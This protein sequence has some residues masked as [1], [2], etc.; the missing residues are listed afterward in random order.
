MGSIDCFIATFG[1]FFDLEKRVKFECLSMKFLTK[2]PIV[3]QQWVT[4]TS[5]HHAKRR[6]FYNLKSTVIFVW[7]VLIGESSDSRILTSTSYSFWISLEFWCKKLIPAWKRIPTVLN[8]SRLQQS[9]M[10]S[11]VSLLIPWI[12]LGHGSTCLLIWA[13]CRDIIIDDLWNSTA[14]HCSH[15]LLHLLRL[16]LKRSRWLASSTSLF[17]RW[18]HPKTFLVKY[19]VLFGLRR[20]CSS[21]RVLCTF[22]S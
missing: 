12:S 16:D 1:F 6:V 2:R 5:T 7:K 4:T 22:S 9:L 3:I 18:T 10:I 21:S 20:C 19:L 15:F 13:Y 14:S 8:L 17:R 11:I